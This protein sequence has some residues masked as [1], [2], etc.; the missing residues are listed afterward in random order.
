M[1]VV[2]VTFSTP[3][4]RGGGTI[5]KTKMRNLLTDQLLTESLRSG[6][7]Y[8]PVEVERGSA[9][10][11]YSDPDHF[12]FMEAD[13]YEQ[14]AMTADE[15]GPSA[16]FLDEGLEGIQT[17][18]VDGKLISVE[19]PDTVVLEVVEADPVI[20]GATAKAQFKRAVVGNGV[21]IKVPGYVDVGQRVK[22]DTRDRHFVE[23]VRD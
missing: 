16:V 1:I 12:H 23:R 8:A 6:D 10:F 19:L 5:A 3:T 4:A 7:R 22:I 9:S 20:K 14:F 15:V 17:V 11:L 2:D 13:T 21:E 18:R